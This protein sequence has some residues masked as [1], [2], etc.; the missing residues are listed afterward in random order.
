M[1]FQMTC[2]SRVRRLAV[3]AAVAAS[4]AAF[5]LLPAHL[6]GQT[7]DTKLTTVLADLARTATQNPASVTALRAGQGAVDAFS[8]AVQDAVRGG[9]LRINSNGEVQVYILVNDASD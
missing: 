5:I 7:A 9:W 4:A 6:V 2:S 3:S 8:P 1:R